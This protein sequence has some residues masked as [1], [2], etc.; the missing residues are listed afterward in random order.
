MQKLALDTQSSMRQC[1]QEI[2]KGCTDMGNG[3]FQG[4]VGAGLLQE[5]RTTG[6]DSSLEA[7]LEDSRFEM[8]TRAVAAWL[9]LQ[10]VGWSIQTGDIGTRFGL[11]PER[12]KR[13]VCL[14]QGTLVRMTSSASKYEVNG[15]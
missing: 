3:R 8:D 15:Q 10:P 13:V 14:G 5:Q 11:S 6:T 4:H 2:T 12:W 9:A 1:P 7:L